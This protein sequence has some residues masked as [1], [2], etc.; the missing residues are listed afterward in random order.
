[1]ARVRSARF[2]DAFKAHERLHRYRLPFKKCGNCGAYAVWRY[3]EGHIHNDVKDWCYECGAM[4]EKTNSAQAAPATPTEL[5]LTQ[6]LRKLSPKQ[7]AMLLELAERK[8]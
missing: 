1:M 6:K 5:S 8:P 3:Y 4:N 2:K 7:L